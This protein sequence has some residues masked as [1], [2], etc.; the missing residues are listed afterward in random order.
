MAINPVEA[1]A[2]G[3]AF[4]V[5]IY[6]LIS[7][8]HAQTAKSKD[9]FEDKKQEKKYRRRT[10][11][12]KAIKHNKQHNTKFKTIQF[13]CHVLHN[14]KDFDE[15]TVDQAYVEIY[16]RNKGKYKCEDNI[17]NYHIKIKV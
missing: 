12:K 13:A 8:V 11:K 3:F 16:V 9:N 5:L 2:I 17:L 4:M 14:R 7:V 6:I 15:E 10:F 1:V